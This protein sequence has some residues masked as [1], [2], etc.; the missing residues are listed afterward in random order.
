MNYYY[1]YIFETPGRYYCVHN[2]M[3]LFLFVRSQIDM[4]KQKLSF[5]SYPLTHIMEGLE[6]IS[7]VV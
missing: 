6:S 4:K 1:P 7:S 5:H 3:W 2:E